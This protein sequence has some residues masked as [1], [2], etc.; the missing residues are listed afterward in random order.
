MRMLVWQSWSLV[1]RKAH[2]Y[3]T[4][5]SLIYISHVTGIPLSVSFLQVTTSEQGLSQWEDIMFDDVGGEGLE[6]RRRR[7]LSSEIRFDIACPHSSAFASHWPATFLSSSVLDQL[8]LLLVFICNRHVSFEI[9]IMVHSE[10]S[11][12]QSCCTTVSTIPRSL[13]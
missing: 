4:D 13:A 7:L 1:G 11:K 5:L 6:H 8:Q 9:V 12:P 10:S 3:W 2:S